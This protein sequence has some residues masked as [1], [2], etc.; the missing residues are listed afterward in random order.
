MFRWVYHKRFREIVNIRSGQRISDDLFVGSVNGEGSKGLGYT[1]EWIPRMSEG[2]LFLLM[3]NLE[4]AYYLKK[5]VPTKNSIRKSPQYYM[6]SSK[7][8][9]QFRSV[10][11]YTL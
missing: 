2:N 9:S 6:S 10:V 4:M 7:G 3:T 5:K 8:L 1:Q 11:V